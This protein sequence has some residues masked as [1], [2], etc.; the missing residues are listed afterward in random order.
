MK[1]GDLSDRIA[2][3][4]LGAAVG[5]VGCI[6]RKKLE[7]G[8]AFYAL[9]FEQRHGGSLLSEVLWLMLVPCA[10]PAPTEASVPA[11]RP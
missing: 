3:A 8:F 5:G 4:T 9:V 2:R 6:P 10:V 7:A 11:E 1:S